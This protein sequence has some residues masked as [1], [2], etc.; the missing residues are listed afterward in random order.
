M[1][2][3]IIQVFRLQIFSNFISMGKSTYLQMVKPNFK[4]MVFQGPLMIITNVLST[5]VSFYLVRCVYRV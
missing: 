1:D 3:Y 5:A 4:A 2:I